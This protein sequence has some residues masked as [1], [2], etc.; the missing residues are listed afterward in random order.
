MGNQGKN[1]NHADYSVVEI[2]LNTEENP[3]DLR[4]LAVT[5]APVKDHQLTLM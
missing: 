5:Q 1:G 3:R 4:R 2:G